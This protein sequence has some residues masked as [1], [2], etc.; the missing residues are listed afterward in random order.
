MIHKWLLRHPRF[1]L[2]FTPTSASWLNQIER[3]FAEITN[4]RIR[5]GSYRSTRGLVQTIEDYLAVHNE[6]PKPFVWT[7]S[8]DDIL[9]SSRV[10]ANG[11]S[12]QH[13]S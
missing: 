3:W 12:I 4:R 6:D 2:H 1:H 13:I 11:L 10:T 9:E 7:K 8:A 5:R